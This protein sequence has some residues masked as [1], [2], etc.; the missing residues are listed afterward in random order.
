MRFLSFLG[1][2]DDFF[3]MV[4]IEGGSDVIPKIIHHSISLS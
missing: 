4:A 1:G 2:Y 3:F